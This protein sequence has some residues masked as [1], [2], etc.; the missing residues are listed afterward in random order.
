MIVIAAKISH[1]FNTSAVFLEK[2]DKNLLSDGKSVF[3]KTDNCNFAPHR[4]LIM[5]F[6][7]NLRRECLKV[8]VMACG[9]TVLK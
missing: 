7:L 3:Q 4:S 9:I 5:F 1:I 8:P 2:Y 6:F